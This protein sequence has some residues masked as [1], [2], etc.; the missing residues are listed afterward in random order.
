MSH[1][2]FCSVCTIL[3]TWVDMDGYMNGL[4]SGMGGWEGVFI[5]RWMNGGWMDG[6]MDGCM[7]RWINGC[8]DGFMGKCMYVCMYVRMDGW[9]GILGIHLPIG[10]SYDHTILP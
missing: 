8:R 4:D 5:D 1:L 6:W 10:F 2:Q 7:G 9:T 3:V